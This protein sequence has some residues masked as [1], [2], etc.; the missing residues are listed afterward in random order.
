MDDNT[1]QTSSRFAVEI[2]PNRMEAW[3]RIDDPDDTLP[4]TT[5]EVLA[6]LEEKKIACTDDVQA[7]A[8]AFV[9]AEAERKDKPKRFEIAKGK[10][11]VE[12]CDAEFVWAEQFDQN[13]ADWQDDAPINYYTLNSIV[14]VEADT[15]IGRITPPVSGTDG[16]DVLGD[17]IKPKGR[18]V[19]IEVDN[20]VKATDDGSGTVLSTVAGKVVF[21]NNK[22]WI[23]E[24]LEIP[25]DVDFESGNIEAVVNVHVKGTVRDLFEVKSKKSISIFGAIE[26]AVVEA[27]EDVVVRGGILGRGKGHVRAGG[28]ITAKFCDEADIS[29][30]GDI[31]IT[32]E[33]MNSRVRCESKLFAEH[34]SVI[35]GAIYA[36]EGV[37]VASLGSDAC[38]PTCI[39]VGIRPDL[40]READ[41]LVAGLLEKRQACVR[42]RESVQ[43]LM[44]NLK[45]LTADQKERAT[46]LLF[47]ADEIEAEVNEAMDRRKEMIDGAKAESVPYVAVSKIIHQGG[48]IRIG[49]RQVVFREELQGP[50]RIEK[51]K[52]KNVTEFVAVN[53]LSGS[54]TVLQS[55]YV[56]EEEAALTANAVEKGCV[57]DDGPGR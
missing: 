38:V 21:K 25:G 42:I 1:T 9:E 43:P 6:A 32:R 53:L 36:R 16:V 39:T 49:R 48:E 54:L 5:E 19:D 56:V 2:A 46:E 26:A 33:L 28:G 15:S 29:A 55:A 41:K 8:A 40:L 51:R 11:P 24:V 37:D 10:P 30:T 34:G 44:A 7:C 3:I 14:T 35:G 17:S 12:G 31:K 4:V 20:T 57:A 27:E 52:V 50:V 22:L 47:K 18:P 45:R 13:A 23:D